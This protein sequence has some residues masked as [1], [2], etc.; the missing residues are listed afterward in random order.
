MLAGWLTGLVERKI[1]PTTLCNT[2]NLSHSLVSYISLTLSLSLTLSH[3][4]FL[5]PY[6]TTLIITVVV[7]VVD[8][9]LQLLPHHPPPP[10][11]TACSLEM[12]HDMPCTHGTSDTRREGSGQRGYRGIEGNQ[13]PRLFLMLCPYCIPF[14]PLFKQLTRLRYDTH[15]GTLGY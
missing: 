8:T 12:G 2:T 15:S 6:K 3:S 1:D 10:H 7:V 9:T 11:R 4:F 14:N 13:Q 5:N